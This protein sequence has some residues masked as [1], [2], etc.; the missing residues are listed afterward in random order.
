FHAANLHHMGDFKIIWTERLQD[1]LRHSRNAKLSSCR[2]L[3]C[4]H[5][6]DVGSAF[7]SQ[8]LEGT[9][10]SLAVLLPKYNRA[11][12]RWIDREHVTAGNQPPNLNARESNWYEHW[13]QRL[14]MAKNIFDQTEP[15]TLSQWWH[16]TRN[17]SRRTTFWIGVLGVILAVTFGFVQS[18]VGIIQ[19]VRS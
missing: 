18:V 19:V 9:L 13:G 16:D 12:Q 1:H 11:S 6:S 3:D 15:N 10:Q 7:P 8:F 2:I 17:S 4:L 5:C 14:S